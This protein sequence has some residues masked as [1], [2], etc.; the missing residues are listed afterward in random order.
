MTIVRLGRG[1]LHWQRRKVDGN[2]GMNCVNRLAL[3]ASRL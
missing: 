2:I 1:I 3:K